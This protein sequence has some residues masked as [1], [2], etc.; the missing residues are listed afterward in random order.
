MPPPPG[1]TVTSHSNLS[2][3]RVMCRIH[4]ISGFQHRGNMVMCVY[5]TASSPV[6]PTTVLPYTCHC[7]RYAGSIVT[8]NL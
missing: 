6:S 7:A 8:T 3:I 1:L 5:S 4:A 2:L